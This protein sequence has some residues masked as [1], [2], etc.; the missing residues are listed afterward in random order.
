MSL[1]DP[2]TRWWRK[3]SSLKAAAHLSAALGL[4][5]GFVGSWGIPGA[6]T[7]HAASAPQGLVLACAV[8]SIPLIVGGGLLHGFCVDGDSGDSLMVR[9]SL[10]LY[11]VASGTGFLLG[12]RRTGEDWTPGSTVFPVFV[13]GGV[14][15]IGVI[16]LVRHRSREAA[17]VRERVELGGVSTSGVVTRA[18]PYSLNHRPVTR[19]TV[20][21]TDTAGLTRWVDRTLPGEVTRGAP[22]KVRYSPND[23]GRKGGVVVNEP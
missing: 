18:R 20:R 10:P 7:A 5:A 11:F 17:R 14:A 9:W 2:D 23:L 16:E 19:V 6:G 3:N 22:V 21:F 13:V 8:A 12:I 4:A 15:A 1:I